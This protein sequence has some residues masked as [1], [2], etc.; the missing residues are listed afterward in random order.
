M[1]FEELCATVVRQDLCTRCGVC[2]GVCP[3]R[4]IGLDQKK[5]PFLEGECID[6]GLCLK[7]CPGA[8]VD[9]QKLSLQ[10]FQCKYIQNDQFGYL[11][12]LFVAH[13]TDKRIRSCGT[14]G[15]VVTALL[16]YLFQ[17]GKIEGAV[18]A[19]YS[20]DDPCQ[21]KGIL[22]T[23]KDQIIDAAQSKYC[24]TAS[25]KVLQEIRKR[26]G[27]FAVVGLPCQVQ[28]IRKLMMADPTIGKKIVCV[29]GLYC[30]CNMEPDVHLDVL[31]TCGIDPAD[32]ARFSFR[33]GAWPGGFHVIDRQ[34]RKIPLHS[35]L[36]TTLLNVL[37]RL[38]GAK[39][40]YLCV[41]ALSEFADISFGDFWAHDYTGEL[42]DHERCT[43]VSQRTSIGKR[44][45]SEA[46]QAGAISMYQIPKERFSKRILNMAARKKNRSLA[47][48]VRL[49]KNGRVAPD[50]HF[51]F[52]DPS[53]KVRCQDFL[54]R[55]TFLL[56]GKLIRNV[57]LKLLFS[58]AMIYFEHVN[59]LRKRVF[60]NY[61]DN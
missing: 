49:R 21:M 12:N 51:S 44:I 1:S 8:E 53:I 33:G 7:S 15:G 30:H 54:L 56:R 16:V 29:L 47:G 26:K 27:K 5:Y 18:V 24:L 34:G 10:F 2:A 11:E 59:L 19:G 38:Y 41:D 13:S 55:A 20:P 48:I 25:M 35:T 45:L 50:Y 9:F 17:T 52:S 32:I 61:H 43:L 58:R 3:V 36:Y 14:S 31:R 4:V 6:C 22:A 37:F 28:G 42:R 46:E 40:C 57:L 39:R 23:S 60:C